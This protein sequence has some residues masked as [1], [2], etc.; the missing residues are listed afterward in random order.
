MT[1]FIFLQSKCAHYWPDEGE[2]KEYEGGIKLAH[3]KESSTPD[4]TLREFLMTRNGE[5]R[6]IYQFHFIVRKLLY[7]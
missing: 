6:V 5:E 1:R 2:V 7:L 4:F 3:H